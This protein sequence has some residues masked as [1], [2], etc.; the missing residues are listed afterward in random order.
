MDIASY[1]RSKEEWLRTF[2]ELPHGIPSHDTMGRF[3]SLL[4]PLQPEAVLVAWGRSTLPD[5][6]RSEQAIA[7]DGKT[8]RRS[9]DRSRGL[10]ALHLMTAWATNDADLIRY[11]D[12]A[13]RFPGLRSVVT[14]RAER[15]I[16]DERTHQN[17][18]MLRRMALR[19]LKRDRAI[20]GSIKSERKRAG[21]D[22]AYL[23]HV[24]TQ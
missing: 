19:L 4:D 1:G 16:G 14:V 17:L 12:P 18:A 13:G 6:V 10:E 15:I 23:L 21:W 20:K 22:D 3:F 11:L 5:E 7:V 24:L 2:L 8:L 9:H